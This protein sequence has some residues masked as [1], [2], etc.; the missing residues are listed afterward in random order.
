MQTTPLRIALLAAA[1]VAAGPGAAGGQEEAG[2]AAPSFRIGGRL[3]PQLAHSSVRGGPG[4]E[5]SLRRSRL[6]FDIVINEW[7]S[8]KIEPDIVG[9][10]FKDA[11]VRLSFESDHRISVGR[12]KRSFDLFELQ[13]SADINV[14]ERDGRIPGLAH[15][16]GLGGVCTLHRFTSGLGFSGRDVGIRLEG[17]IVPRI[18]YQAALTNGTGS[19]GGDEND[20]KSGS[21]RILMEVTDEL[22][23]AANVSVHDYPVPDASTTE[24]ASAWGLDAE[25]GAYETEGPHV[26][27]GLV[28]GDNWRL[29]DGDLDPARFSAVQVIGSYYRSWS[30]GPFSAIEPLGRVSWAGQETPAGDQSGVLLTPGVAFHLAPRNKVSTNIDIY[31]P[32]DGGTEWSLKIQSYIF[33]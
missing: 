33:F 8:G 1:F 20:G 25:L 7:L 6:T 32:E 15:C 4:I 29:L 18:A 5:L 16:S 10:G 17:P 13:S 14:A 9:G 3:Q 24:F 26:Q 23:V 21:G 22:R 30:A 2:A 28:A 19:A 11:W 27:A 12:F 31:A